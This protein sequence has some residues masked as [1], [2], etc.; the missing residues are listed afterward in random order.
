MRQGSD[1][2]VLAEDGHIKQLSRRDDNAVVDLGHALN[3][4]GPFYHFKIEIGQLI[5]A[6]FF[7]SFEQYLEIQQRALFPGDGK[8]FGQDNAGNEDGP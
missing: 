3:F 2:L 1:F 7:D 8:K 5:I 4:L 6:T